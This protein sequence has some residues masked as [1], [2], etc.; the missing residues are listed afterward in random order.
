MKTSL[1]INQLA[2]RASLEKSFQKDYLVPSQALVMDDEGNLLL[3]T[4]DK[5][6]ILTASAHS[7]R[8]IAAR[9]DIPSR[10]YELM[11]ENAPELLAQNVNHWLKGRSEKRMVRTSGYQMR[12][13]LSDSYRR[14]DN[15]DILEAV[16]PVIQ[17]M[18]LAGQ[19][20]SCELTESKLY[21]KVINPRVEAEIRE[22]DIVQSGFVITNSEIGL[23]AASVSPLVYRLVC[24]NG[25]IAQDYKQRKNHVG[26]KYANNTEETYELF[27]DRTLQL[28]DQ[29]YLSKV[30]D[31]VRAMGDTEIFNKIVSKMR[32]ATERQI[33]AKNPEKAVEL[34]A[35]H[36][37]LN[38]EESSGVLRH[39]L[40]DGDLT[41]YGMMNAVTRFS[42]DIESYDRAT[43]LEAA[44]NTVLNFNAATWRELTKV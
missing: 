22:G 11:R 26:R 43:E 36:I 23:G 29:A 14:I 38:E 40:L 2:Q 42:Q 31:L 7:H 25:L 30:V 20:A 13:F 5:E 34:T 12:A 41:Q 4:G 9:L 21:L 39:L 6:I 37:G 16:L 33:D 27:S 17:E 28:D 35:N 18:G 32:D 8:Q 44:G 24:T 10:Y 15:L 1:T 3:D 19:I